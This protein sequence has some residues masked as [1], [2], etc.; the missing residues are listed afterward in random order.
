MSGNS[1]VYMDTSNWNTSLIRIKCFVLKCRFWL[2]SSH[3]GKKNPK[4]FQT[5][6]VVSADSYFRMVSMYTSDTGPIHVGMWTS[7]H[8]LGPGCVTNRRQW[9]KHDGSSGKMGEQVFLKCHFLNGFIYVIHAVG[10]K[11]FLRHL[12]DLLL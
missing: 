4:S 11:C 9:R 6:G 2:V 1:Y 10:Y 12:L 8:V 5:K 7:L 3:L